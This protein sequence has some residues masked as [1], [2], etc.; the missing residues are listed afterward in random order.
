MLLQTQGR[1]HEEGLQQDG[2]VDGWQSFCWH[3]EDANEGIEEVQVKGK[4]MAKPKRGP[5]R[6]GGGSK[7]GLSAG[8]KGK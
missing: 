6:G 4:Q 8:G 2:Q 1:S 5:K 3:E 7:T